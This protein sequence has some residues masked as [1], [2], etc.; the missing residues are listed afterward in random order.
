MDQG[1]V[2]ESFL[3]EHNK[4]LVINLWDDI[5]IVAKSLDEFLEGL[6]LLLD[7]AG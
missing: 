1:R 7:D 6:S 3:E 5:S 4:R 2:H